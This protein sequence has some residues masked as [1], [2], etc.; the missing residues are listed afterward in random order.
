M[1]NGVFVLVQ[2]KRYNRLKVQGLFHG[3]M[4]SCAILD[5]AQPSASCLFDFFG[6]HPQGWAIKN[7]HVHISAVKSSVV[8]D[9]VSDL[10]LKL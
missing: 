2:A 6:T 10:L 1:S 9:A 3:G 5:I 7:F 4:A 8:F